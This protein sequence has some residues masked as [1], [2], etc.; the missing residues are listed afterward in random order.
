MLASCGGNVTSPT[1][2]LNPGSLSAEYLNGNGFI[3]SSAR[4]SDQ[5]NVF[6]VSATQDLDISGAVAN[7]ITLSIPTNSTLPYSVNAQNGAIV[8]F[9]D[10]TL[11]KTF[12]A[13][14]AQGDCAIIVTQISPTF[15]GTFSATT[16]CST[17]P[18][19]VSK[20]TNGAF[21]ATYQ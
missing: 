4:V 14:S 17:A 6:I 8:T 1:G 15:E 12:E 10:V 2:P 18:D 3:S 7:E 19:T 21:N 11:D 9:Y 5:S 16:I 13:N 20:L